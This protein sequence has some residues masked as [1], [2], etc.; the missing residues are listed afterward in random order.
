MLA[1]TPVLHTYLFPLTALHK[2]QCEDGVG[3]SDDR[4][5]GKGYFSFSSLVLFFRS[6][7]AESKL[8]SPVAV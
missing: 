4:T 6:M 5:R 2:T 1:P 3:N 7:S 8:Q